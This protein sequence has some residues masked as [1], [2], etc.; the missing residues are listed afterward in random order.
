MSILLHVQPGRFD[1]SLLRSLTAIQLP[2]EIVVID[3]ASTDR[4]G[5]LLGRTGAIVVRNTQNV[6]FLAAIN[7]ASLAATRC[8]S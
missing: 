4:T 6:G 8:F 2:I 1:T 7:P 3:N 5:A